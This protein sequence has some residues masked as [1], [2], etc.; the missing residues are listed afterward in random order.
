MIVDGKEIKGV[1]L[2]LVTPFLGGEIDYVSLDRLLTRYLRSGVAGLVLLGTTGESP[3]LAREERDA[4]V[5]RVSTVVKGSLPLFLGIAGNDTRSV[6]TTVRLAEDLPVDGYLITAPYYNRPTQAGLIAHFDALLTETER[7]VLVYNIPY[8]TGV[9]LENASLLNLVDRHRHLV[10]VKDSS[11]DIKQTLELLREGKDRLAVLTGEDHLFFASV[12]CGGAGGI[13]AAAHIQPESFVQVYND[14][15]SGSRLVALARWNDL[16]RW[17]GLLFRESNP[18]PVKLWLADQ[19]LLRS[20]ECRLPL[21]AVSNSLAEE[22]RRA[23]PK[24]DAPAVDE[25]DHSAPS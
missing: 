13:L 18:A 16:S 10:G 17:I 11:G 23:L 22:L 14:L 21:T 12:A 15:I 8:R 3:V 24:D 2:P 19:G 20:P 7:A 1:Y 5:D 4:V 9:N 25:D 6:A